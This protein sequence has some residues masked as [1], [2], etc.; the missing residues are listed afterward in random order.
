M[1]TLIAS[2]RYLYAAAIIAF[3]IEH[4]AF[5]HSLSALILFPENTPA[6]SLWV[7]AIGFAFIATGLCIAAGIRIRLAATCL[8]VLFFLIYLTFHLPNEIANPKDPGAWTAAFELIGL[9]GGAFILARTQ[10]PRHPGEKWNVT[11]V[12]LHSS[13]IYFFA[14]MFI[15]IGIQHM[16]YAEFI[17]PLIPGWIPWPVFWAYFIGIA[18]FVIALSLIL[19]IKVRLVT[20]LSGIMFLLW[21]IILHAPRVAGKY[22]N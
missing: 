19:G 22:S 8:G 5:G 4:F 15:V 11:V 3:G 6:L 16:M 2:G 12:D 13:G 7:Y 14:S 18:F 10:P 21:V 9:C 20:T 17:A 1:E